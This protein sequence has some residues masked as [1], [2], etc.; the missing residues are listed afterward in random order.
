MPYKLAL[1]QMRMSSEREQNFAKAE[2]MV[3]EAAGQGADVVCLPELFL[4]EYFCKTEDCA[5]FDLAEEIPGAGTERISRLAKELGIIIIA[6]LFEKRALGLYHNTCLT[7]DRDGSMPGFYR[8]M[9][10]PDDPGFYEKYY[11]TQGDLGYCP[12]KTS[13]GVIGTPVCWDQWYP[14][15]ARLMSLAGAELI[16]YPTAIGWLPSE[17]PEIGAHQHNAWYA[18]QRGHAVANGVY[19]AA[20]NRTGFEAQ[21]GSEGINFWGQSFIIDP[22]G[23]TIAKASA[24]G[25]EV[26]YADIDPALIEETRRLWPFLRDR[27]I[28]SYSEITSR[29]I[30]GDK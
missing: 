1:V 20:C 28:D 24:D 9:H 23:K 19:V 14:E 15:A 22:F 12:S 11:F 26:I 17:K 18:V 21:E 7:F 25:E 6:S 5:Y 3:R 29:Y 4:S 2:T 13:A 16:V 10:I 30:D 8:K 27:R